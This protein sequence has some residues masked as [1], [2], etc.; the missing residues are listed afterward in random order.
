[1][2]RRQREGR[3]A[4]ERLAYGGPPVEEGETWCARCK[5]RGYT[6]TYF[7]PDPE[8]CEWCGGGFKWLEA[9]PPEPDFCDD[10]PHPAMCGE[11]GCARDMP[12]LPDWGD[13]EDDHGE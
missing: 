12:D 3:E 8:W 7:A 2:S 13:P 1:M 11:S 4:K 6:Y 5:G 10:C 9:E